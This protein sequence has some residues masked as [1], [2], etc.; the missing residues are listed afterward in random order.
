MSQFRSL[1]NLNR[2]IKTPRITCTECAVTT[3]FSFQKKT[4][5]RTASTFSTKN[6]SQT[7]EQEDELSKPI[8][9][10]TSPAAK[11]KAQTS[12]SGVK[13]PRLW[14]EPYVVSA[15]LLIFLYYFLVL[16]EES[17]I[18]DEFSKSLYSRIEGL[19]EQQLRLALEYN[20]EHGLSGKDLE[21]RLKE[22]KEEEEA[23]EKM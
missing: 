22:I 21:N 13:E 8:K 1:I 18:D 12:R 3:Q 10:S 7:D 9:F 23:K 16:R 4:S 15:S 19:E 5:L 14:Y 20:K 2:T 11:W 17:D 6:K